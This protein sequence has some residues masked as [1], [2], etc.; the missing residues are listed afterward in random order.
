[1]TSID[2]IKTLAS[3][4]LGFARSNQ[5]LVE[6]PTDFSGSRGFLGQLTQLLTSGNMGGNDL[7]LLCTNASLPGKQIL[8]H[9]RRI[10]MEFQKVAYGYAVEDVSLTFYAL[11]DYGIRKYWDSWRKKTLSEDG[12]TASYKN[13][14]VRDVRIHQLRKPILNLG[15]SLGPINVNVGIGGGTVYSVLLKDAF[16]TSI[17]PVDLSNEMDGLVQ[18]SA[19]LSYTNWE[20]VS[21]GQ[22]WIQASGG[23][24]SIANLF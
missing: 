1:M 4:K 21:D 16:P 23:L 13:E 9:E 15:T 22:G 12:H 8:S 20:A 5:F 19:Q 24:G 17:Q 7:N 11:N 3:S 18:I 2:Q 14:Y 6:L 10:G